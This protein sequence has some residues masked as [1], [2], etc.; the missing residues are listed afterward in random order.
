VLSFPAEPL[1]VGS[2][3]EVV[4][5]TIDWIVGIVPGLLWERVQ[6]V[7]SA[8]CLQLPGILGC[9]YDFWELFKM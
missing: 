2:R 7:L 3:R 6:L 8:N 1:L 4:D 9:D 5:A